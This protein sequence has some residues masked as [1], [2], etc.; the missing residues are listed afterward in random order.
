MGVLVTLAALAGL[1][2][3]SPAAKP[4]LALRVADGQPA[5]VIAECADFTAD[6]IS[7]YTVDATPAKSWTIDR[8]GGGE[9][10]GLGP[11]QVLTGGSA[12]ERKA[13]TETAFRDE[14]GLLT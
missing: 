12:G 2:A 3:C 14:E 7:V 6:R 5:L 8:D 13:V 10:T 11:E 4:V 9:V 1:T